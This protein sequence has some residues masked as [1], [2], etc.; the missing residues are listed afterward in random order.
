MNQ[1]ER[2]NGIFSSWNPIGVPDSVV[3]EEYKSYVERV[4][5]IG[6]NVEQMVAFLK[7]VVVVEMGLDFDDNNPD[8]KKDIDEIASSLVQA[9]A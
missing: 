4:I 5:A 7:S 1:E 9:L 6:N 2:I 3:T 8:H